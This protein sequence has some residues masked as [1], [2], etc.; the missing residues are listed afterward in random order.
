MINRMQAEGVA[1][2][3]RHLKPRLKC[4]FQSPAGAD[5]DGTACVIFEGVWPRLQVLIDRSLPIRRPF[6]NGSSHHQLRGL[7]HK[8]HN[9]IL[10]LD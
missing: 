6:L 10:L 3:A 5:Q 1:A 2:A 8:E 9:P 7:G 4:I